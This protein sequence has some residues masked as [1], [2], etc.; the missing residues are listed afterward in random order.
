M[1]S[2]LA[3]RYAARHGREFVRHVVPAV[4]KPVR[5]LWNDFI[6]FLFGCLAVFFGFETARLARTYLKAAPADAFGDLIRLSVSGFCT[7]VVLWY[8]LS[9]YLR[10]RKISRS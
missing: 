6:A 1:W 4:A 2:R 7:V 9:S 3:A 8:G 10:A 5:T